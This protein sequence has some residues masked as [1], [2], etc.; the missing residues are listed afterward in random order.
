[1]KPSFK[2]TYQAMEDLVDKGLVKSIGVSNFSVKKLES[3][4]SYAR[5]FPV[6]NQVE[7]HPYLRQDDL[8]EKCKAMGTHVTAYSPLGSPDSAATFGHKGE[9][10]LQNAVIKKVAQ[11]VGRSTAAVCI[12]WAL[13]R[14]TSVIPKSVNPE[15]IADNFNNIEWELSPE[16]FARVNSLEPQKRML[17]FAFW[18]EPETGPYRTLEDIWEAGVC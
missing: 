7:L 1:M 12:K 2:E 17:D 8:V 6:V 5:Y 3:M 16:Q 4:K 10:V 14:G 9:T 11:E 15:R 18:L 13:Q